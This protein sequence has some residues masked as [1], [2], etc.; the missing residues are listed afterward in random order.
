MSKFISIILP[1]LNEKKNIPIIYKNIRDNFKQKNYEI[2]FVDD[3]STDGSKEEILKIY[4][5]D[6]KVKYI[7]RKKE[8]DLSSSFIDGAFISNGNYVILMDSDLQHD[9]EDLNKFYTEVKKLNL[10]M[11]IGSR[12]LKNSTNNTISYYYLI[13][14]F[15]SKSLIKFINLVT[16]TKLSD[17]LSGFF[18]IKRNLIIKYKK[19]LFAS[20]FKIMLDIYLSGTSKLKTK[21]IAITLNERKNGYSK[22]NFS[23]LNK[24][25]KLI[26]YHCLR[27][28]L[29]K[30]KELM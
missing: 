22:I 7:F 4:K 21:E 1:C 11:V 26:F 14:L 28:N 2:I 12:F 9:A 5:K 30:I 29:K 17:P 23:I 25:I 3:N 20:G 19:E 16:N 13:R 8:R 24:I 18:L 6:R 10:D 15:L 27:K